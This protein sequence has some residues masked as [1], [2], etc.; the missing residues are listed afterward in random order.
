MVSSPSFALPVPP[1]E[2]CLW[3][4]GAVLSLAFQ[5]VTSSRGLEYAA[6]HSVPGISMPAS[7]ALHQSAE[8]C[9]FNKLR[10]SQPITALGRGEVKRLLLGMVLCPCVLL[11][12]MD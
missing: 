12:A 7:A 9:P 11:F 2:A 5:R 1:C 10:P 6:S 8:I 4:T 3:L